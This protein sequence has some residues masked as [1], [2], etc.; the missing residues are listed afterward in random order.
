MTSDQIPVRR[1]GLAACSMQGY[2]GQLMVDCSSQVIVAQQLRQ[3][4][5]DYRLLQPMLQACEEQAGARPQACFADGG[6]WSEAKAALED[7]RTRL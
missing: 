3:E 2:N 5:V 7:E 1:S 4:A 6:Y